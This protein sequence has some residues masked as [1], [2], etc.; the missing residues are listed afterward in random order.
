M[1]DAVLRVLPACTTA[2]AVFFTL[3]TTIRH[4]WSVP[5][6]AV[7]ILAWILSAALTAVTPMP[8]RPE[9]GPSAMRWWPDPDTTSRTGSHP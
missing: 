2:A 6:V 4:G 8:A 9:P 7:D 3:A 1:T 5:A